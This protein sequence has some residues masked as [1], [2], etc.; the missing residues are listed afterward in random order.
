MA[1]RQ[2]GRTGKKSQ[3]DP[4]KQKNTRSQTK[5]RDASSKKSTTRQRANGS[6][7]QSSHSSTRRSS[8]AST[9][10]RSGAST[11][12][13]SRTTTR[14]RPVASSQRRP[15]DED[16]MQQ[17]IQLS[18]ARTLEKRRRKKEQKKK[19]RRKRIRSVIF[20][21]LIAAIIAGGAWAVDRFILTKTLARLPEERAEA[22]RI[23]AEDL[24]ISDTSNRPLTKAEKLADLKQLHDAI[25]TSFPRANVPAEAFAKWDAA[26][27]TWRKMIEETTTDVSFYEVLSAGVA[28]LGNEK[29]QLLSPTAFQ[30]LSSN[31]GLD[32]FQVDSPYAKVLQDTRV[33]DRYQR[34]QATIPVEEQTRPQPSLEIH[35][36]NR[37][38]VIKNVDLKIADEANDKALLTGLLDQAK[39]YPYIVIDLRGTNGQSTSYWTKNIAGLLSRSDQGASS[40]LFL[41]EGFD[42]FVDY[43]SVQET[44][45]TFDLADGRQDISMLLPQSLQ[46]EISDMRHS[47]QI[48]YSILADANGG[49]NGRI[50]LLTDAT[51][52]NAA[53][54]FASF[55]RQTKFATV[56]G[57]A[58]GGGGWD[59][60]PYLLK[61]DHSG[62]VLQIDATASSDPAQT[63][64]VDTK[65]TAVDVPLEGEDLLQSLLTYISAR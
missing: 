14:Q 8:S 3:A 29:T 13:R 53:D 1:R 36:N 55:S 40:T 2:D 19:L 50:Y 62:L 28:G 46:D 41:K 56:A 7:R 31:I 58:T 5:S 60:P 27:E 34:L 20:L 12:S 26:Y 61:L 39:K 38:A 37:V 48:T 51:T 10:H 59:V 24:L 23:V 18:R 4:K 22:N 45:E 44:L 25:L 35:G 15:Y 33:L 42:N 6:T 47:K 11:E 64:L 49:Y 63:G 21:A 43:L 30:A 32:F 17:Q 54:S 16:I 57:Q 65:K 9:G 52:K